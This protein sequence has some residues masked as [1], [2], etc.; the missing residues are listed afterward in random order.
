[1]NNNGQV[2][3]Q[4]EEDCRYH[5]YGDSATISNLYTGPST[6]F[7]LASPRTFSFRSV[8]SGSDTTID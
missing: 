5:D 4:I 6:Y 3:G 8:R 1:M 7:V 2:Q